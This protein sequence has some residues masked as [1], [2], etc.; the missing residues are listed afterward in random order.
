MII[1]ILGIP[2]KHIITACLLTVFL[3]SCVTQKSR[4]ELSTLG[5]I[6]QNTTARYNGYFNAT[7]LLDES[8]A[9]LNQ[10]QQNNYHELLPLYQYAAAPN[11]E[12]VAQD[13][14][15][16]IK[17][18]SVVVTLHE[19]S[20]WVDDCYLLIGQAEYL[21]Q[22]FE[23]SENA[24]EF[25]LDEFNPNGTRVDAKPSRKLQKAKRKA[26]R[27]RKSTRSNNK[28]RSNIESKED[29]RDEERAEKTRKQ[30]EKER[31]AY[32]KALK[33]RQKKARKGK[34]SSRKDAPPLQKETPETEQDSSEKAI[35][36]ANKNGNAT[37]EKAKK[38]KSEKENPAKDPSIAGQNSENP[39]GLKHKP[40]YQKAVLWLARTYTRRENYF[41]AEYYLNLLEKKAT[42]Q[43][44]VF[45]ALP[46]AFAEHYIARNMYDKAIPYLQEAIER[47][48]QKTTRARYSYILA[49]L[50]LKTKNYAQAKE[51]FDAVVDYKPDYTM[52]FNARI[53]AL[54]ASMRGG[55]LSEDETVATLEHMLKDEKNTEFVDQ[56]YYALAQLVYQKGN[57]DQAISYLELAV[58]NG[59]NNRLQLAE[60]N[61][62]L[63][64]LYF[65]KTDYVNAKKAYDAAVSA[66]LD[67]D[68][69]YEPTKRLANN[70]TE[71]AKHL[72][73]IDLQ[74]SLLRISAMS[75]GERKALAREIKKQRELEAAQGADVAQSANSGNQKLGV[76][77]NAM[78]SSI[79]LGNNRPPTGRSA[80]DSRESNF[81]AYDSKAVK[82]GVREF[83]RIWGERRLGDNWRVSSIAQSNISFDE[84]ELKEEQGS[85]PIATTEIEDIFKDVPST[86]EQIQ[87]AHQKIQ[88]A[89]L[90]LG[91]LYR[92]KLEDYDASIEIL[93]NLLNKYPSTT[94]KLE[95]YYQLY[96]SYTVKGD[97]ANANI[98]KQKIIE[99]YSQSKY[100]HALQNP[101]YV[102]EQLSEA[103]RISD[104]YDKAFGSFKAGDPQ[105]AKDLIDESKQTF[106]TQHEMYPK[107]HLL[108]AM[109][110]GKLEG[111]DAYVNELKQIIAQHPKTPEETK[112][113]DILHLLGE[114]RDTRLTQ[115]SAAEADFKLQEDALH[116]V[117]VIIEDPKSISAQDAKISISDYHKKYHSL[118]KLRMSSLVFDPT[119]RSFLVLIR[120][121][122]NQAEAMQYY[123]NYLKHKK[124]YLPE[125]VP[126]DIY[127][128]TQHNYREVIKLRSLDEYGT[129]FRENY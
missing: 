89:M 76:D 51:A 26:T 3:V 94:H 55:T 108:Y 114:A 22:D 54:Q 85:I 98:Y 102:K 107:Y 20:Q 93:E 61:Y 95:A 119:S 6:Y 109:A 66:M 60:T 12:A 65:E 7:V 110:V 35:V 18:V 31:K 70:L 37:E 73:T 59:Q 16:A 121:F 83:E 2:V 120:S 32:N 4:Y 69:R 97:F 84:E 99:E 88:D 67:K 21:K 128:I 39:G 92:E 14:D 48:P 127:P 68:P 45:V 74:D 41:R 113:R 62:M 52:V 13:L 115:G 49:Q 63:G 29:S 122:K 5:K 33:K 1:T 34:S 111:K 117:I 9:Q 100:A 19:Q 28:S 71:I 118:D 129:F 75:E 44:E 106:G 27:N 24:L 101:D 53:Q 38:D 40:A 80:G 116:F 25:F 86:D 57:I 72:E 10:Q 23:A 36:D 90:A 50:Y 105:K 96:I 112:A 30:L 77:R 104:Y 126:F 81:F 17:K 47:E 79:G 78:Q 64:N 42:L 46:A 125:G 15:E 11:P 58:E 123:A 43:D 87:A 91:Q 8:I 103:K 124:E 82:R 56:I